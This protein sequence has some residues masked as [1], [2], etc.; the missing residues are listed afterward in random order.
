MLRSVP[1]ASDREQSAGF[2]VDRAGIG[3]S[4]RWVIIILSGRSERLTSTAGRLRS[5]KSLNQAVQS[6]VVSCGWPQAENS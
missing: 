6:T 3:Q 1:K 5:A 4:S 2:R